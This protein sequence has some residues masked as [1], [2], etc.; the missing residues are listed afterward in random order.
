MQLFQS[1]TTVVE[2]DTDGSAVLKLDVPDRPVNVFNQQVLANLDAALDVVAAANV[3]LLVVR[4]GKK[5]GFV[6]GADLHEFLGIRDAA[7]AEAIS[8]QG[9]R[10]FDKLAGLPMPSVAAIHGPC[11]GGGLEFALACDYRL[12]FD[13]ASTQ[14]GLPEVELGLLPAWGGTQRLP[15][16]VGLERALRVILAGKRLNAR[17]AMAW[18]LA[19]AIASDEAGL[20]EEFSRLTARALTEGKRS[21][22]GLPLANWRQRML[23]SNPLGRRL[24]FRATERVLRRKVWDDMPAP[25]EAL[26]AIRVGVKNGMTEGLTY[27][28]QAAGRLALTPAC[29]N[30]IGLFF[31][32][33]KARKLPE[34][35]KAVGPAAVGRVGVV[36]AGTMGAGI[37]QLAAFKGCKVVVQEVSQAAL[38]AGIARITALFRKAVERS[39]L[40]ETES[41]ARLA[42]IQGTLQWE[43][44]ANVDVA[45]EAA[46]EDLDMKRQVFRQLEAHTRPDTVLATNTSSLPVERLQEGLAHPERVAG[47]HFFNPVHKMPLI[48]VARAPATTERVLAT[49]AQWSIDLGKT[50]VLVRDSPGFVVNRVLMP[51]LNEA[52]LL[53]GEGLP[54]DQ[55][56]RVMKRFGMPM[57]PLEL[58]D[59]IGLDVAAHVA[60]AMQPVLAGRFEPNPAFAAMRQQGWLGQ[61]SGRGFYQ[62][63]GGKLR[64]NTAAQDLLRVARPTGGDA[65]PTGSVKGVPA[66]ARLSE[67]RERMVLSMVNEAALAL[68][69]RLAASAGAIDLAM[70]LGTGWAP[71]RGGPL[72]YA[73]DRGLLDVV[74]ALNS[75]AARHGRRFEPCAELK[76]RA[77]AG[78]PF[79]RGEAALV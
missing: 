73:D 5:S 9:Q 71:H 31:Q 15:R 39:L 45:V 26:E 60:E 66:A 4:S 77:E 72:R 56:D 13:R 64:V 10:L 12:V 49:L 52:V 30:L 27:E 78:E 46:L 14:L 75:L 41:V 54:I 38:D 7:G 57:G 11:L 62:H 48:E 1:A 43:G 55:V 34:E 37:A 25:A 17:E 6:A 63:T 22:T 24:L 59:Q 29:R 50:P 42:A 65:G 79:T 3:P 68:A 44:F 69:E 23:E 21:R 36:G 53:V 16:V 8:A 35:L 18:G 58:L 51:Y 61:K 28:R 67:G 47:L 19:D 40:S 76:R 33:E 32:R 20:R 2:R 74:Q 70:V